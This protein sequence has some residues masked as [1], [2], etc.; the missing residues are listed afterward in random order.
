MTP[1]SDVEKS[2]RILKLHRRTIP[3]RCV[4]ALTELYDT[5]DAKKR[6]KLCLEIN[7]LLCTHFSIPR[8]RVRVYSKNRPKMRGKGGGYLLGLYSNEAGETSL[9]EL[10]NYTINGR[11]VSSRYLFDTYLHEFVHH[12]DDRR[13]KLDLDHDAGFEARLKF[14]QDLFFKKVQERKSNI[15]SRAV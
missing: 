8:C 6:Q 12:Y 4:I 3:N 13:L 2:L 9:I 14:I 5:K 7:N 11:L 1:L 15:K 10:W